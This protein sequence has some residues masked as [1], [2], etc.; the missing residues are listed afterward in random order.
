MAIHAI[1]MHCPE[2]V[3]VV[4][5]WRASTRG[6]LRDSHAPSHLDSVVGLRVQVTVLLGKTAVMLS[7]QYTLCAL[8]KTAGGVVVVMK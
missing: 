8:I 2:T 6:G 1:F 3:A 5:A 4:F 7:Y